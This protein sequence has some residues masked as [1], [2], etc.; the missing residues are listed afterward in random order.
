MIRSAEAAGLGGVAVVGDSVDPWSPKAVRASAGSLFRTPILRWDDPMEALAELRD[1]GHPSV[2]TVVDPA[3]EP[4]DRIDL[5]RAAIL[6]GNEPRGLS[7][8]VIDA[9]DRVATIPVAPT[10]ESLNVAAAAAVLCFEA[11]RQGRSA[12]S[13]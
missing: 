9:A 13:G 4:Y 6:V 7:D 11:A 8:E 3:A 12:V 5:A 10:V 2:A 1:R